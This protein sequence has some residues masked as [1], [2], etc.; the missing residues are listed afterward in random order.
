MHGWIPNASAHHASPFTAYAEVHTVGAMSDGIRGDRVK[1]QREARGWTQQDL[2][3]ESGIAQSTLSR[4]ESGRSRGSYAATARTLARLFSCTEAYLTGD[5][6]SP[7]PELHVVTDGESA[8]TQGARPGADD[9][10]AEVL[11]HLILQRLGWRHSHADV[12]ILALAM[13]A[14]RSMLRAQ[15]QIDGV[16]LAV[17]SRLPAWAAAERLDMHAAA[18]E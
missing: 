12:W 1:E 7:G 2:A 4:I 17:L 14:P 6:S 8:P 18:A 15:R 13:A 5:D 9:V 16:G 10:V 11:A 3:R